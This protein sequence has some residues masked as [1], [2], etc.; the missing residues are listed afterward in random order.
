MVE[1]GPRLGVLLGL[2]VVGEEE[3]A[4]EGVFD[5]D[6]LGRELDGEI[7]G[8]PVVG[9]CVTQFCCTN[10]LVVKN[11]SVLGEATLSDAFTA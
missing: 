8:M 6:T 7:V 4:R 11:T 10:F 1:A 5:G 3:G 2:A 9:D